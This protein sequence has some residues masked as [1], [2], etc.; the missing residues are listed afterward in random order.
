MSSN[1]LD[2]QAMESSS[3]NDN[4]IIIAGEAVA[5]L[6]AVVARVLYSSLAF[7]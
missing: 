4:E 3:E 2:R 1:F 7:L 6:G 5:V